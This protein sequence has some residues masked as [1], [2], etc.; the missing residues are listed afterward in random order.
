MFGLTRFAYCIN[1]NIRHYESVFDLVDM[2]DIRKAINTNNYRLAKKNFDKVKQF[3]IDI[4][5]D[6]SDF[7]PLWKS[8]MECF[9]YIAKNGYEELFNINETDY[10]TTSYKEGHD[11]GWESFFT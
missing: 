1:K 10:W 2:N 3:I 8:N 7:F 9:E 5:E 4:T 11:R 6:N